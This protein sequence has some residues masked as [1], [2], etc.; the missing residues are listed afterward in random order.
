[1]TGFV[2]SI[3]GFSLDMTGFVLNI[4]GFVIYMTGFVLKMTEFV[5]YITGSVPDPTQRKKSVKVMEGRF[6]NLFHK[7]DHRYTTKLYAF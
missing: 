4:N 5:H 2:H 1:M 6:Y 7:E 3:S